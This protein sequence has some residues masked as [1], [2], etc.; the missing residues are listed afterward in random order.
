MPLFTTPMSSPLSSGLKCALITFFTSKRLKT[1][2]V[3]KWLFLILSMLLIH[4]KNLNIF[5]S[6]TSYSVLW[7]VSSPAGLCTR[8]WYSIT[9]NE[10]EKNMFLKA[11]LS[12]SRLRLGRRWRHVFASWKNGDKRKYPLFM[13]SVSQRF[14]MSTTLSPRWEWGFR[15]DYAGLAP[16][17]ECYKI[18]KRQ[19][20]L[21][22][23]ITNSTHT[24][25]S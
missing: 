18:K 4:K 16:Q 24:A 20:W 6:T 12:G 21:L 15:I 22:L 13:L 3:L 17:P 1:S 7:T 9:E 14:R 23:Q 25:S 2:A 19:K 5:S 8:I 10:K 11:G